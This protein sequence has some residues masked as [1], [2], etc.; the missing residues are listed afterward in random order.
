M[1]Y[2]ATGLLPL[3]PRL[4]KKLSL[5]ALARHSFRPYI[6]WIIVASRY[7]TNNYRLNDTMIYLSRERENEV[8]R[9]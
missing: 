4:I 8:S 1:C 9:A 7:N 3:H 6:I 2:V 5:L